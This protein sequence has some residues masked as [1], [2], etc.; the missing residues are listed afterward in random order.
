M[1]LCLKVL[2][3]NSNLFSEWV[4][5]SVRLKFEFFRVLCVVMLWVNI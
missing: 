2:L 4:L 3:L 1:G 5:S